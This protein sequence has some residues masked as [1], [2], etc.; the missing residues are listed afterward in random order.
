V[1]TPQSVSHATP[2]AWCEALLRGD[3]STITTTGDQVLFDAVFDALSSALL[4]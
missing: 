3:P 1:S 2:E 4:A